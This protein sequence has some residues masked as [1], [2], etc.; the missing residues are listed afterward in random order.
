MT[1]TQQVNLKIRL[2]LYIMK[3]ISLIIATLLLVTNISAQKGDDKVFFDDALLISPNYSF[4]LPMSDMYNSYG[5]NHN[6][7]LEVGYKFKQNW[8]T[9]RK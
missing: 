5:F 4:Q 1:H 2:T 8:I 6:F 7:G 9:N 3:R